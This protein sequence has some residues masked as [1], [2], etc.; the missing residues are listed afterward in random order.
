MLQMYIC[1]LQL[2]NNKYFIAKSFNKQPNHSDSEFKNE[3]TNLYAPISIIHKCLCFDI[4]DEDM[5]TIKYMHQYG[6]DNVRGGSFDFVVLSKETKNVIDKMINHAN[7][8]DE[9]I[10]SGDI[11]FEKI[12]NEYCLSRTPQ[13]D[14][15]EN[16]CIII[17]YESATKYHVHDNIMECLIVLDDTLK[18]NNFP[19]STIINEKTH[20]QINIGQYPIVLKTE[21]IKNV[22]RVLNSN[23]K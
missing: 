7:I 9:F 1:V 16:Q 17:K 2:E 20:M 8:F 22:H 15:Q 10:G 18:R 5:I 6:I 13:K 3:W 11:V 14:D 4:F 12:N 19:E 21:I 23:L